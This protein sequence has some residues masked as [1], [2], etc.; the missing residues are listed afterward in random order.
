[1]GQT[2]EMLG[3]MCSSRTCRLMLLS[4]YTNLLQGRH[5]KPFED[6]TTF[7]AITLATVSEVTG[8]IAT[9]SE[10][11]DTERDLQHLTRLLL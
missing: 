7:V 9:V 3:W 8:R 4:E 2:N 5:R 1:M 10:E 11:K 6:S